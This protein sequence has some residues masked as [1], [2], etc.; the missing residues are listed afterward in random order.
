MSDER[1]QNVCVCPVGG[2]AALRAFVTDPAVTVC[3]ARPQ[4][5]ES[6]LPHFTVFMLNR[7]D[8]Q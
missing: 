7:V 4:E 8:T 2:Y 5:R 1:L 3:P 6:G